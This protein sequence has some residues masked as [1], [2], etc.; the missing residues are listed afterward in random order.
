MWKK[1]PPKNDFI[2]ENRKRLPI[3]RNGRVIWGASCEACKRSLPLSALQVDHI[4]PAGSLNGEGE[5]GGFIDRLFCDKNNMRFLCHQCHSEISYAESHGC[6][7]EEARAHKKA[8]AFMKQSTEEQKTILSSWGV[9]EEDIR[10]AKQR[11]EQA[12]NHYKNE[13]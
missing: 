9:P 12:F 5:V 13:H 6:S 2:K 4:T 7:V 10:N 3:G 1:Y 11:R 8:I